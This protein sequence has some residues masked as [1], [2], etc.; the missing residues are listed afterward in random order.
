VA[1]EIKTTAKRLYSK[2]TAVKIDNDR[3][4]WPDSVEFKDHSDEKNAFHKD[5]VQKALWGGSVQVD[6]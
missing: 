4:V 3:M 1:I 5:Y 2:E 6:I